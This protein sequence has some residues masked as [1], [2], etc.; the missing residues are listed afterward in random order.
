[1][2]PEEYDILYIQKQIGLLYRKKS[3]GSIKDHPIKTDAIA[4]L[5]KLNLESAEV[6]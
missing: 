1:M 4:E 2:E 6:E 5:V 3:K